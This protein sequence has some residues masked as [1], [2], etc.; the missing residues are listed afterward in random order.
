MLF[1][2]EDEKKTTPRDYLTAMTVPSSSYL[3]KKSALEAGLTSLPGLVLVSIERPLLDADLKVVR[4][5]DSIFASCFVKTG[6]ATDLRVD[7]IPFDETL[8]VGDILWFAGTA[9]SIGDLRYETFLF[10]K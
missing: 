10:L 3:S 8:A 1:I 9:S 4:A 2:E 7:S 5:S 6:N